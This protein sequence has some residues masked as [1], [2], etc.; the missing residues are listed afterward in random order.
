MLFQEITQNIKSFIKN[1][2]SIS[3]DR[4][5][6]LNIL[7]QYIQGKLDQNQIPKLIVICT[8]NSRRSHLGQLWL[9]VG[10]DYYGL[11][12][13]TY[14]GG[15]EATA[16]HPNAIQALQ[17]L[18]FEIS[19][20]NIDTSNPIYPVK[21]K[22]NQLPY[23]AFSKSFEDTPNPTEQFLAIMVCSEAN[24][25]CPFISGA[26]FRVALPFNDPK[27]FDDTELESNK[28]IECSKQI[29][30]EMMYALYNVTKNH[31]QK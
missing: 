3:K 4:I 10:A 20:E 11:P 5:E 28:Y 22:D 16:F 18:G 15:T 1:F 25:N 8:H 29:G 23:L 14:S 7:T 6:K 31:T 19:T 9:A 12:I 24:E 17:S 2:D 30:T 27:A 26:D 13:E 21:W